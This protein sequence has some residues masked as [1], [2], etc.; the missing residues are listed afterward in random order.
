[1]I[2]VSV[3]LF[4]NLILTLKNMATI[5][6]LNSKVD[7]LQSALTAEQAKI[8]DAIQALEKT[9]SDLQAALASAATPEQLQA[10]SAKI[11]GVISNLNSTPLA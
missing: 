10:V 6:D 2:G 3:I 4:L 9:N 1:M 11:D 8:A 7:N 5:D